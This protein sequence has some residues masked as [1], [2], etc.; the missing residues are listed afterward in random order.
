MLQ[1]IIL[2]PKAEESRLINQIL[3]PLRGLRMTVMQ[4]AKSLG[5]KQKDVASEV[6][7]YRKE[8]AARK[9]S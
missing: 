1:Y 5:L 7:A 9:S 4:W 3:R 8:K 2:R 6:M